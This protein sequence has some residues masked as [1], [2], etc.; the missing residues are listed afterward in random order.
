MNIFK[1]AS[2]LILTFNCAS[3]SQNKLLTIDNIFSID[4]TVRV[5]FSGNPA[6]VVWSNEGRA[7]RQVQNG[8]LMRVDAVTGNAS[9]YFDSATFPPRRDQPG[10]GQAL[11]HNDDGVYLEESMRSEAR[12]GGFG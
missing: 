3:F 7:Y 5:E 10:A 11:V 6:D 8:K 2:L 9:E 4:P 12:R 1:S